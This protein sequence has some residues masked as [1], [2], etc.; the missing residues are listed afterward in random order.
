MRMG[1]NQTMNR[2][3]RSPNPLSGS[4]K[5]W[6]GSGIVEVTDDKGEKEE[7]GNLGYQLATKGATKTLGCKIDTHGQVVLSAF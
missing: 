6:E 7:K 4:I 1:W 5:P 3:K 2:A